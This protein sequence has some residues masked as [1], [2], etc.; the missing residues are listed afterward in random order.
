MCSGGSRFKEVMDTKMDNMKTEM[1]IQTMKWVETIP[2]EKLNANKMVMV[3]LHGVPKFI[4]KH[5]I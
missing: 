3:I 4:P 1:K 5:L 2:R